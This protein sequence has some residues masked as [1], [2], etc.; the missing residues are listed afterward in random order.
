MITEDRSAERQPLVAMIEDSEFWT[1]IREAL[2]LALDALERRAGI[3]PRTSEIRRAWK[4][5]R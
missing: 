4:A 1:I 3:T 5:K 2:L